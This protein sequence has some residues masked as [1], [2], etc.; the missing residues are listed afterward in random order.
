MATQFGVCQFVQVV[1][2]H[3]IQKSCLWGF[4]VELISFIF[5]LFPPV[6]VG[7]LTCVCVCAGRLVCVWERER[8]C[9]SL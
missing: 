6:S 9:L 1:S 2:Q 8:N 7:R 3:W 5:S 4:K